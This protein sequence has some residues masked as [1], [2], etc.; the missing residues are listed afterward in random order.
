MLKSLK[1]NLEW[2]ALRYFFFNGGYK[3]KMSI[4]MF[5]KCLGVL[6]ISNSDNLN[7]LFKQF[8]V[9]VFLVLPCNNLL[10]LFFKLKRCSSN[11]KFVE[12]RTTSF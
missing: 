2:L 1:F 3:F 9:T 4:K 10:R 6:S 5:V 11:N 7:I 12:I 8:F